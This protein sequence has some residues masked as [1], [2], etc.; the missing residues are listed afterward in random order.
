MEKKKV[1]R[2][3]ATAAVSAAAVAV[4][5]VAEAQQQPVGQT[6][7]QGLVPNSWL[8]DASGNLVW[9]SEEDLKQYE[10]AQLVTAE[11]V[12]QVDEAGAQVLG[13]STA[14]LNQIGWYS[15]GAG[16][17]A[18]A[19]AAL[20][21]G[22]FGSAEGSAPTTSV[23]DDVAPSSI[24]NSYG[25]V[26]IVDDLKEAGDRELEF[27]FEDLNG[28]NR[29][30][31]IERMED[32][33]AHSAAGTYVGIPPSTT[34]PLVV[35]TSVSADDLMPGTTSSYSKIT[36][37]VDRY[38]GGTGTKD[39][40][41]KD[42][43]GFLE[44]VFLPIVEADGLSAFVTVLDDQIYS[45]STYEDLSYIVEDADGI[46]RGGF[47]IALENAI[48]GASTIASVFP[49]GATVQTFV[50]AA[51]LVPLTADVYTK[52]YFEIV[53]DTGSLNTGTFPGPEMTF[54]DYYGYQETINLQLEV[55]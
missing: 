55:L 24:T 29:Q 30:H 37:E 53:G 22:M 46:D 1:R 10:L 52:I 5:L 25:S 35:T 44:L 6:V 7:N 41:Y 47:I 12:V 42:E 9:L 13:I 26:T 19:A 51:D 21:S 38:L 34:P 2:R 14:L 27:I 39:L 20:G 11:G 32:T 36:A 45:N 4:P 49:N 15:V 17:A 18:G 28:I 40:F 33:F 3:P 50:D 8:F 43:D 54:Y 48:E 31:L 16:A 23:S